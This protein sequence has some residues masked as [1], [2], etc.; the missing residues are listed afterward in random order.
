MLVKLSPSLCKQFLV[1]AV[2]AY[3]LRFECLIFE[4]RYSLD[5]FRVL[6]TVY[7]IVSQLIFD[8]EYHFLLFNRFDGTLKCNLQVSKYE[9]AKF[10]NMRHT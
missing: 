6:K 3:V 1:S 2:V 5:V 8:L 4:D 7:N 10:G 9:P